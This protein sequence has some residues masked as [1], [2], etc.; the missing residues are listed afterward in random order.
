MQIKT[1]RKTKKTAAHEASQH[2]DGLWKGSDDDSSQMVTV[3]SFHF[4]SINSIKAT[5]LKTSSRKTAM[6]EYHITG[7]NGILMP[8]S[9]FKILFPK[10]SMAELPWYKNEK[11]SYYVHKITHAFLSKVYVE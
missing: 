7:S 2:D 4:N 10:T 8:V 5:K 11:K 1:G 9:M 3:K 6:L